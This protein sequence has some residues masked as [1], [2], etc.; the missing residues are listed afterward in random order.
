M[1][2][3]TY[4]IKHP[5]IALILNAMIVL[6]GV[7]SFETLTL[8]EYPQ[9]SFPTVIV[10]ANYPNASA[11][12]VESAVTNILEDKLAGVE[13]LETMTSTSKEGSVDIVMDFRLGTDLD[14][15]LALIRDALSLAKNDLPKEVKDP[16]IER[17][18]A[19]TGGV[20]FFAIS[21]E[22]SD[23][24]FGAVTH[25]VKLNLQNIF[26]SL[27][28]VAE[29]EVWGQPYTYEITLDPQKMYTFGINASDIYDV[30][31]RS[32]FSLPVGKFRD[33]VPTTLNTEL[34]TIEDYEDLLIKE[35]NFNNPRQKQHPVLLKSVAD[36]Q[37]KTNDRQFRVR[38]NGNP[39]L[40]LTINR[41]NDANPLEVSNLLRAQIEAIKSTLPEGMKMTV[42]V[43]QAD[44]I[45]ASIKG[46]ESSI[47]EAIVLVLIIVFLFLRNGR[48]TLIPLITIPISLIGSLLL[49]KFFGCSLNI[50]TLLAMVLAVGLVVDDA[51]VMLENIARH[52]EEGMKPLE[53]AIKGSKEIGF[54]IV[55]MTLTLT[56]VY[57]PIAFITGI[58]G[59]LFAEF[60][61]ALAG[62][63]LISGVVALTLSPLM[64]GTLIKE[65]EK[66]LWPQIDV[67]LEKLSV[68]YGMS[69]T[70]FMSH[71]SRAFILA[72]AAAGLSVMIFKNLPHELAPKEDRGLLG[73]FSPP[74]PGT[75]MDTREKN[76][77][78]IEQAIGVPPEAQGY[79]TF[80]GPWGG[81][82]V[83]PMTDISE[84]KRSVIQIKNQLFGIAQG[85]PSLNVYPWSTDSGLPGVDEDSQS[86]ELMLVVS[87]T[88]SYRTLF[89]QIEKVMEK[90]NE[91]ANSPTIAFKDV[92]HDLQLDTPGYVIDVDKNRLSQLNLSPEQI[93][94]TIEIFFSG[95][96]T[97]PMQMDGLLYQISL[98][99]KTKPWDLNELYVTNRNGSRISLGAVATL[100]PTS[101]PASL[102]HYNQMRAVTLKAQ[103]K[104]SHTL[105][106]AMKPFLDGARNMLPQT[107]KENWTG[108]AKALLETSSTMLLLFL[109]ALVF[110]YAILAVQF[111]NFMDPFIVLLTVPLACSGALLMAW[112]FG[113]SINIYTQVGLITLVGLITK[114]GILI[115]EFTNQLRE[116]GVSLNEAIHRAS[117]LRLRPILMTT[118]AMIVGALPLILS[119]NAGYEARQAIGYILIGGLSFGTLFTLY[120]I[121]TLT[122]VL[123]TRQKEQKA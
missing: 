54:A 95:D 51:I 61:V 79:L 107:Y 44:F 47:G 65:K 74:I 4:F 67:F 115:V 117:Q 36:I 63:I 5:V 7:L 29:A 28:G 88:D 12:L 27:N 73:V 92:G 113:Q 3:T 20:P 93:A 9:V 30:L 111:E 105:A 57:A 81:T 60:A 66:H 37:L 55:A 26:R 99:G 68:L 85:I 39:G 8:R 38:I 1:N 122:H 49:L 48:A 52:I 123:K 31:T 103:I 75:D 64:C 34:K 15:S 21:I 97:I 84:R 41:A 102:Y 76:M 53:A 77:K 17:K 109:L 94:K 98:K 101:Q 43:D 70:K 90:L 108:E 13:G 23:Q 18:T 83:F 87:T 42:V 116:Q 118:C 10:K 120:V 35:K 40:M 91:E 58:V 86:G 80:M 112:L 32:H 69:L 78:I 14:R 19:S 25:Y 62:S 24:N 114:H 119:R 71:R 11:E 82:L 59:Q 110:V 104:E 2:L 56:S 72:L 50:I 96:Q 89:N 16:V 100:K 22:S 106:E 45:R 46:I 6:L 121:P 33:E